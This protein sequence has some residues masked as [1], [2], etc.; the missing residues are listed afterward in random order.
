[1][2]CFS[3]PFIDC[4]PALLPPLADDDDGAAGR[5]LGMELALRRAW[6]AF[7][8]P[9]LVLL[10]LRSVDELLWVVYAKLYGE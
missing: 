1:M 7:L 6:F 9:R 3:N 10:P 5:K 8:P 4:V 2:R